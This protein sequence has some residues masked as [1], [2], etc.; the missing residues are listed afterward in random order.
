MGHPAASGSPPI[1]LM[2]VSGTGKSTIGSRLAAL[3]E[4]PF[5]D[6]DDLHSAANKA[7]MARGQALSDSDRRPWLNAVAEALVEGSPVVACSALRRA[8]RGLLRRHAPAT[9]FVHLYAD[10]GLLRRRLAARAHE[11]MPA[12]LL[13]SQL[14]TLEMLGTDECGFE[15]DVTA[16]VVEVVQSIERRLSTSGALA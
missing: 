8:Y 5:V 1:V 3:L 10:P 7:L 4:R 11:Y 14:Q 16:P 9:I 2:G 13:D 12:S 15:V 6:G